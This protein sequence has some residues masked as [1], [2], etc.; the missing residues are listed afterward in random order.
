MASFMDTVLN[1]IITG[2]PSIL[3][4]WTK[5]GKKGYDV[6]NLIITGI[7]SIHVSYVGV[8]DERF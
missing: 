5:A 7:P 1:L 6:L 3:E 4:S 8:L 2:I